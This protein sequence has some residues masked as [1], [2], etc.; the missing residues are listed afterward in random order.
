MAEAKTY[1]QKLI[2]EFRDDPR[3]ILWDLWNEP[4]VGFT[5][6]VWTYGAE[7]IELKWCKEAIFGPGKFLQNNHLQCQF[8]IIP[9]FPVIA[10]SSYGR[11]RI[12]DG[13][14]QLPSL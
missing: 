7:N 14:P 4:G 1:V 13:Y 5:D 11:G 6:G 9:Q 2:G 8:F 12:Y 3:I 10:S